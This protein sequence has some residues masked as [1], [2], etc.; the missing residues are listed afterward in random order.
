M[1][2]KAF[3]QQMLV[4]AIPVALQ[5]LLTS[6]LNTLDTVMISSLGDV[7]IAG[8]GLANQVFF[9][10]MLVCFGINTGSAVL[11]SQYWGSKEYDQ[12]KRVN[13]ISLLLNVLMGMLFT[14]ISVLFPYAIVRLLIQD[15]AVVEAGGHYLLV[16]ASTYVITALSLAIGN[17]LRCTGNPK[18]PLV[19]TL[20]SF[21]ANAFFNY[22]FIFGKFGFP[23]L[24]VVGAALGTLVA[25][26]IELGVL[27]WVLVQDRGIIQLPIRQWVTIPPEFWRS[28]WK[29]TTPVIINESFWALGQVMYSAAFAMVGRQST[30][31]IQVAFAVQN[32]SFVIVRGLGS[33]CS[34]MLGNSI[35]KNKIDRAKVDAKRFVKLAVLTGII[36]GLLESLTPQWTLLIFGKLSNEVFLIGKQLLQIMGIIFILKALNSVIVVG[37]L[38]GGGDTHY[39]M[40]LE[41]SCVWLVG[42]PLALLAAGV[43]HLPVTF[44]LLLASME[45]VV[46]AIFGLKRVYS[47]KWIHRLAG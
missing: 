26:L 39:G 19:A 9:L 2:K 20:F 6:F 43:W 22:V 16:A 46:K 30:A 29:T 24:G 33:S 45:E 15:A 28:Y 34:I 42:V 40:K 18:A 4:I 38:R 3:Y 10:L 21:V 23:E 35:G 27:L 17:A 7:N 11:F 14:V 12:V 31:A 32:L 47:Y 13:Q 36:M 1:E 37:I 41:M 25:R 8:V 44:V 5:S